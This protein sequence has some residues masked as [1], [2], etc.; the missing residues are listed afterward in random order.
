M[1]TEDRHPHK[2]AAIAGDM[3]TEQYASAATWRWD[4]QELLAERYPWLRR[5]A[6]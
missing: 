3:A 1:T 5:G 6:S 2:L 4:G